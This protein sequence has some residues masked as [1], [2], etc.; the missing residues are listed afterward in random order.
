[1]YILKEH[2]SKEYV[3]LLMSVP[4]NLAVSELVKPLN[5]RSSRL[6]LE[7]F[8]ELRKTYWDRHLL[9]RGYF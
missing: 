8:G 7:E 6:L 5:G 1:M 9:A 3:N 4:Q 2:V